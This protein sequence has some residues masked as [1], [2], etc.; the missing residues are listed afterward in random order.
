MKRRSF[1]QT[2][3]GLAGTTALPVNSTT[4]QKLLEQ[5]PVKLLE[6]T[7]AGFRYYEGERLFNHIKIGDTVQLRRVP[8]NKYDKRAIEV[9]WKGNMLGHIP[10]TGN[11]GISQMID[12]GEYL[13]SRITRLSHA[14]NPWSRIEIEVYY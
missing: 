5:K 3:L 6:T 12:R 10:G 1:L 2:I 7:I 9:Y 4:Q 14:D 11:M 8:D 13:S